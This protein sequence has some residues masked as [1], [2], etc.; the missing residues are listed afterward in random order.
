MDN[1]GTVNKP[2]K[3]GVFRHEKGVVLRCC[4]ALNL[5]CFLLLIKLN[6]ARYWVG[7]S[8]TNIG[9]WG[10]DLLCCVRGGYIFLIFICYFVG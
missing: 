9:V 7:F 6:M 5:G 1:N 10:C 2:K 4:F 3:L 8:V